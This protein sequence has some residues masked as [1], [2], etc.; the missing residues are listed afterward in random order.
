MNPLEINRELAAMDEKIALAELEAVKAQERVKEIMYQK[1]RLTL[2][3]NHQLL[4]VQQEKQ[5]AN[6]NTQA[7]K[8]SAG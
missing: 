3:I 4:R 2:D 8:V 5:N 7:A 1:A 6:S